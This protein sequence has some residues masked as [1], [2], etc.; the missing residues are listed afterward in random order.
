MSGILVQWIIMPTVFLELW[1]EVPVF[2][3]E[4]PVFEVEVPVFDVHHL[5]IQSLWP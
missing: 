4:V 3:V 1:V 5:V 2:E